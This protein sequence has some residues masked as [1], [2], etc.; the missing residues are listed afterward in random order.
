MLK[1]LPFYK[2]YAKHTILLRQNFVMPR[3]CYGLVE[4]LCLLYKP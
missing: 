4:Q 2:T 1:A 3:L